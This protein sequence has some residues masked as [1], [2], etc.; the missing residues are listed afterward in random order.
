[1][2]KLTGVKTIDMVNGEITKVAYDGAE[3]VKVDGKAQAGDLIRFTVNKL[4][5]IDSGD[6]FEIGAELE[7]YDN[8]GDER[9]ANFYYAE[10][11]FNVFRK[12]EMQH[13][14]KQS[15]SLSERVD[16]LEKRVEALEGE[17]PAEESDEPQYVLVTDRE[18]QVGDY[19]KYDD[20]LSDYITADK[21]YEIIEIDSYGDPQIIDDDGDEYDTGGDDFEVY[22]KAGGSESISDDDLVNLGA[23]KTKKGDFVKF[24]KDHGRS[25]TAGKL[26]EVVD[27]SDYYKD[28][29]GYTGFTTKGWGG[30]EQRDVYRLITES[31]PKLKVGDKAR[32]LSTRG[33]LSGFSAGDIV[34]LH[35]NKV[36]KSDFM[37]KKGGSRGYTNASNLE[38]VSE[39]ELAQE[40]HVGDYVKI[41]SAG[42]YGGVDVGT[43]GKVS[44]GHGES[45]EI[46]VDK[47]D[48]SDHDY[49]VAS[50]LEKVSEADTK[51]AKPGRKQGEFKKGD[52]VRVINGRGSGFSGHNG[53]ISEIDEDDESSVPYHVIKPKSIQ[54]GA[55]TWLRSDQI[56]LIAPVESRGDRA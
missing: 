23:I 50:Q 22:A 5:D 36:G 7:Y 43:I 30:L 32:L 13:H 56:E 9:D 15:P 51:F 24:H 33:S 34:T 46:R 28:D 55:D 3:Y 39:E 35:E 26:Y 45:Y 18:P 53:T 1:M 4:T 41:L 16:A 49:F 31:E 48:G 38:K 2:A 27:D 29:E 20:D 12:V 10:G 37:V 21:Y 17:A 25:T 11:Y 47:L 8:G 42:E 40:F 14:A 44:V 54:S 52:I 19:V 6:F